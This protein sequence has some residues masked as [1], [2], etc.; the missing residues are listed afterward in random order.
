VP[1][2]LRNILKL[3]GCASGAAVFSWSPYVVDVAGFSGLDYVRIDTEHAWHRDGTLEQLIRAAIMGDVVPIVRIDKGDP[4]LARKALEL[5]AGGLILPDVR[6]AVQAR[7][8][9]ASSKFPP[10]GTRGYSSNCWSAGWG[11]RGGREWV[12]ASNR[13]PLL[14]IMIEHIEAMEYLD[15]IA[16][17]EG[18]DF[19]LFGPSDFA[20]SLGM[21]APDPKDPRIQHAITTTI[22]AAHKAGIYFSM[23]VGIEPEAI[24]ASIARG[25][26]LLEL[27]SDLAILRVNWADAARRIAQRVS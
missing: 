14:G 5:G 13:D 8:F 12:Q 24:Q 6:N 3:N 20:M 18:L 16:S 21:V 15:E 25:V 4:Y 2:K 7:D 27:A 17:I 23:G 11:S 10:L 1:N 22:E 26:N 19:I 9:I